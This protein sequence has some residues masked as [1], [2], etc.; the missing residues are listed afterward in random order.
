MK[1]I[2]RYWAYALTKSDAIIWRS[3]PDSQEDAEK[4]AKEVAD[5]VSLYETLGWMDKRRPS[6][7]EY[8]YGVT[9]REKLL[10]EIHDPEDN[11][12]AFIT[13]N[14]SGAK[15]LNIR[16]VMFLDWD[17]PEAQSPAIGCLFGLFSFFFRKKTKKT[18][19]RDELLY[20][21]PNEEMYDPRFLVPELSLFREKIRSMPDWSVRIYKTAGGYR[22]IVTHALFDPSDPEALR[23]MNEFGCDPLYI[24]LC[25]T[26]ESFRARL[27]PKG[28]RCGLWNGK[29]PSYFRFYYPFEFTV[30]GASGE[31]N[32][33][34][35]RDKSPIQIKEEIIASSVRA[36]R[37]EYE[38]AENLYE[39]ASEPFAS[40]RYIGTIGSDYVHPELEEIIE[41]H[42]QTTKAYSDDTIPLA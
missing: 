15:V 7:S 36:Y 1:N 9:L 38:K 3:S 29:L 32:K 35:W 31:F 6:K 18:D 8:P 24:R 12:R 28:Y 21:S 26:Q 22:G 10:E 17:T 41:L 11:L 2:P 40:C 5:R 33:K 19:P 13:R 25:R 16:D 20:S 23:T 39:K 34:L 37:E 30:L 14:H 42:D 4:N 27:T